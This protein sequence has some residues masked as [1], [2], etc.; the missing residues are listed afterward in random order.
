MIKP[1]TLLILPACLMLAAC[2]GGGG[3]GGGALG[4]VAFSSFAAIPKPGQVLLT[5]TSVEGD[6]TT[7][8][9]ALVTNVTNQQQGSATIVATYDAAGSLTAGAI[10]GARTSLNYSSSDPSYNLSNLG[11]PGGKLVTSADGKTAAAFAN[12][13]DQGNSYQNFGVWETGVNAG[14]GRVGAS[15]VGAA[16]PAASVPT[17]GTANFSGNAI[18]VH[19]DSSGNNYVTASNV[20]LAANFGA[21]TVGLSTSKTQKYNLNTSSRYNLSAANLNLSGSLTYAAGSNSFSGSVQTA[22]GL[23]G[24]ASG[25]F[26]GPAATEIGGTFSTKAATGVENY[27]GAF[28]A[29]R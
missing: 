15:S 24:T 19:V 22:S 27:V 5:G 6:F 28:G 18:G 29:K 10:T 2:G 9:A 25:N 7:N 23:S 8:S 14:A 3:G 12:P 21:R 1:V 11:L 26:Y 17:T 4:P 16:T 20:A 13:T